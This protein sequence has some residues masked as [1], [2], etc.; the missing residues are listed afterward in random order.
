MISFKTLS[1][2]FAN[3]SRDFLQNPL[4]ISQNF[5]FFF[6][7]KSFWVFGKTFPD[8]RENRKDFGAK[9]E[10]FVEN[11]KNFVNNPEHFRK[12]FPC[13][14][15]SILH[16]DILAPFCLIRWNDLQYERLMFRLNITYYFISRLGIRMGLSIERFL[17]R[18]KVATK[19][20]VFK[21]WLQ[22]NL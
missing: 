11:L 14:S 3:S 1:G 18:F 19:T 22:A 12:K 13:C 9:I 20:F 5:Q 2:L 17:V 16:Y 7:E 15:L 4:S 6:S 8:F 10:D 21:C